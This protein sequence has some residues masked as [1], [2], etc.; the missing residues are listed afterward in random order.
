MLLVALIRKPAAQS[1]LSRWLIAIGSPIML[2]CIPSADTPPFQFV[3]S[4]F[5]KM[6]PSISRFRFGFRNVSLKLIMHG[7]S[8]DISQSRLNFFGLWNQRLSVQMKNF[9]TYFTHSQSLRS[10]H[11]LILHQLRLVAI[12]CYLVLH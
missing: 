5:I 6:N 11:H 10:R 3:L 1:S 4:D 12:T 2:L 8:F 9:K 7:L